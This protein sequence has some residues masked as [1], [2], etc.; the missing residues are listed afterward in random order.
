[1]RR[2]TPKNTIGTPS[3]QTRSLYVKQFQALDMLKE[4]SIV[5]REAAP[6]EGDF[7][8]TLTV[9]RTSLS[10]CILASP[11]ADFEPSL[12]GRFP[13]PYANPDL[14]GKSSLL[15]AVATHL[16]LPAEAY[17]N[18]AQLLQSLWQIFREKEGYLLEV[19]TNLSSSGLEVRG[20]RFG[21]DDAAYKSSG[22][23]EEV[24]KL[25]NKAEEVSEEVEAEKDGIVYVKC[26]SQVL[27]VAAA[28]RFIEL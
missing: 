11:T 1:M 16:Q 17:E 23:Q 12:T 13:F 26:V 8:L 25:R 3:K 6:S 5:V 15:K 24:H 2:V 4:K 22:R 7:F 28:N 20:A 21:F 9:D 10:P 19:R 14:G 27:S 18:L